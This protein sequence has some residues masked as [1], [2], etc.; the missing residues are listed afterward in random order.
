VWRCCASSAFLPFDCQLSSSSRTLAGSIGEHY[1]S[2][3][4]TDA[5]HV[6]LCYTRSCHSSSLQK[7]SMA[8]LPQLDQMRVASGLAIV[9][10]IS[11]HFP[12][13]VSAAGSYGCDCRS[14][15][16]DFMQS[17]AAGSCGSD[18]PPRTSIFMRS[19]R[20]TETSDAAQPNARN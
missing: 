7:R 10:H 6:K 5:L 19:A 20:A 8:P 17:A 18:C 15:T 2:Q 14:R 4:T 9:S 1:P 12:R 11:P 13:T 3:W 16:S